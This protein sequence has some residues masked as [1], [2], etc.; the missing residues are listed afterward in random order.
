[1]LTA[2]QTALD[3]R[4]D[5]LAS[6]PETDCIRL[7]HGAAEG[8]PGLT[9][10]RYGPILLLQT[11]REPLNHQLVDQVHR[12]ICDHLSTE[13]TAVWNHRAGG[14]TAVFEPWHNPEL[15]EELTGQE[16]GLRFDVNPRH[17]GIDPLLFLDFR[18]ARR[19]IRANSAGK[20]VLNLFSYTCT[21]G[22]AAM[23]GGASAVWNVDFAES[24][25]ATGH[26]NAKLN[27]IQ[28]EG[29]ADNPTA[30]RNIHEDVFPVVR[31]LAGLKMQDRRGKR[32][33]HFKRRKAQQ[34]DVVVLDPPRWA[35]S[36]FGAVD[37]IRD[38]PSLFKPALLATAPG[39]HLLC[40]N[41]VAKVDLDAWTS[42]LRR[43]AEKAGRPLRSLNILAPEAD[44]PS[45]DGR[46][47][48]KVA[49][50]GV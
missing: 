24:A 35:R 4:T 9:I 6:L 34:F 41:N 11:W 3:A 23:A 30:W 27:G 40:T 12:L 1:M 44:F 8:A 38:Y 13:L 26:A 37:V 21:A 49:W 33:L 45:F 19:H 31:Q 39:G 18:A 16:L 5:L 29:S 20:S 48:L 36:A 14:G 32:T 50:L 42:I 46:H 17:R 10:D 22:V 15:P 2:I 7:F 47:P 25:L 43:S 28:T